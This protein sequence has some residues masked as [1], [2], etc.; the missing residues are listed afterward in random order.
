MD[1]FCR[2]KRPTEGGWLAMVQG[3]FCIIQSQ[4]LIHYG[5]VGGLPAI[6]SPCTSI[7]SGTMQAS[8]TNPLIIE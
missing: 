7:I 5:W 3:Y 8:I 4:G 1:T 6:H 2:F